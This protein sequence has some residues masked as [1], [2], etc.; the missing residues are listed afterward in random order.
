MPRALGL[1]EPIWLTSFFFLF[2]PRKSIARLNKPRPIGIVRQVNSM[3]VN[4]AEHVL[5][6]LE[7]VLNEADHK[8]GVPSASQENVL[9]DLDAVLAMV[10]VR[11]PVLQVSREL[12]TPRGR[13]A[14]RRE[15]V[16]S[17]RFSPDVLGF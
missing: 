11:L 3:I 5:G 4:I 17:L 14:P 8:G 6:A 10:V 15:F 9:Q 7:D 13:V 16:R 1:L 2:F 12:E